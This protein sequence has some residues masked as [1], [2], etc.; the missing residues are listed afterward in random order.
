MA[1]AP[2]TA[3]RADADGLARAAELLAAGRIV[4]VP[5]DTVYGIAA[6]LDRP[7]A[8]RR[9]FTAKGRPESR[10]IPLLLADPDIAPRL[11]EASAV[12]APLAEAFWPGALTI[13]VAARP[14]LPPEV[15]TLSEGGSATVALRVPDSAVTR[16]L[17]RRC[18]GVLAVTSANLSGAPPA[19]RVSEVMASG[20]SSLAA[21][22]DGGATPGAVPSTIVSVAGNQL[23]LIRQGVIPAAEIARVWKSAHA[24]F[25][26]RG[27]IC[28]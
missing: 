12:L 14:G 11:S 10:A 23:R 7:D 20:L 15:V 3:L 28:E 6:S 27:M 2:P 13:V 17:C 22:V 4:A 18:G 24:G 21:A 25:D 16:D 8:L 19:T 5:T 26:R 9:L 1:G